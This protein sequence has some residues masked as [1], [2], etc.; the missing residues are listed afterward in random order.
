MP[1]FLN[2]LENTIPKNM[3]WDKNLEYVPVFELEVSQIEK[4]KA[5]AEVEE[6]LKFFPRLDCGSC[7]SPTCKCFAEDVVRRNI[8]VDKCVV[9]MQKNGENYRNSYESINILC[10]EAIMK[11]SE[12]QDLLSLK[13]LSIGTDREISGGFCGDLLSWV[14]ANAKEDCVWFTVM[15]NIN[16]VAVAS[17]N[18]IGCIVLCQNSKINDIALQKAKEEGIFIFST[19][20]PIFEASGKF[21]NHS[22]NLM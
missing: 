9:N 10:S 7:G 5:Y 20:M 16:S 18:D 17:L 15:G 12:L 4:F 21:Y 6:I 22:N 1:V 3:F 2:H 11:I 13:C 8:T 14:M 19:D